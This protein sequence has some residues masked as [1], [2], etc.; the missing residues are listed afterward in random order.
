MSPRGLVRTSGIEN[1]AGPR[2]RLQGLA[3]TAAGRS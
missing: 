2:S 1:E 3:G